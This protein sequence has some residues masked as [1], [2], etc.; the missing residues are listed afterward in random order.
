MRALAKYIYRRTYI[1][2][3]ACAGRLRCRT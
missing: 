3:Q 1:D 2:L